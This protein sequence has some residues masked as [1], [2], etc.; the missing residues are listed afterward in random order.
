MVSVLS[1]CYR[2]RKKW[3]LIWFIVFLDKCFPSD[4]KFSLLSHTSRKSFWEIWKV[5]KQSLWKLQNIVMEGYL[6]RNLVG[7]T[8]SLKIIDEVNLFHNRPYRKIKWANFWKDVH[9]CYSCRLNFG[10]FIGKRLPW[11]SFS[12]QSFNFLQLLS[13][14]N[15]IEI[16]IKKP[17]KLI[18]W[19]DVFWETNQFSLVLYFF[20]FLLWTVKRI[21]FYSMEMKIIGFSS[22]EIKSIM[23][24]SFK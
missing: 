8:E 21:F 11:S 10:K 2:L 4:K 1:E 13:K 19:V 15:A 17:Q 6:G 12:H 5:D 20:Y 16:L 3:T 23:N 18:Y 14:K 7:E 22:P 9:S 24:A